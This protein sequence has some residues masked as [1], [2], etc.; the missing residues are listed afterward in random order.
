MSQT[1][2]KSEWVNGNLVFYDKDRNVI[3]TFDGANCALAFGV[4]STST[5]RGIR[6]LTET[7]LRA[8]FTDGGG[9]SGTRAMTGSIPV[10][11]VLLGSKV[12]VNLGFTGDSSAALIIGD[13]SDTDRY[14]TS[15]IDVFTT[16]ASGVQSG[17]PSGNKLITTA[18]APT[19]TITSGSDFT[20]VSAGSITVSLFYI[21][22]A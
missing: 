9:T 1:N 19:L 11:A 17:I 5:A 21:E 16:A 10:G 6:S 15:T 4:S 8:D 14:N 13:G 3:A 7:W 2:V 18:N 12:L 22:T 20:N